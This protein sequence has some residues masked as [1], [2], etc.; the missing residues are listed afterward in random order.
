MV[1]T[2][3]VEIPLIPIKIINRAG[4]PIILV[5]G[6][7]G[8]PVVPAFRFEGFIEEPYCVSV[9]SRP[10]FYFPLLVQIQII[11]PYDIDGNITQTITKITRS[12][13]LL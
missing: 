1:S 7:V 11:P 8:V 12:S 4:R 3:T 9:I 5:K 13:D 2:Y 6:G 10:A